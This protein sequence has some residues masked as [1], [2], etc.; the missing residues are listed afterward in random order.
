MPNIEIYIK[1]WDRAAI[2]YN[3]CPLQTIEEIIGSLAY[4]IINV[5]NR[6]TLGSDTNSELGHNLQ[7]LY[8]CL[9]T[10]EVRYELFISPEGIWQIY[11]ELMPQQIKYRKQALFAAQQLGTIDDGTFNRINEI[12]KRQLTTCKNLIEQIAF[13][14]NSLLKIL[15]PDNIAL[16]VATT[17]L[18]LEN[19]PCFADDLP[20]PT[21]E[22]FQLLS[23]NPDLTKAATPFLENI[24]DLYD[25]IKLLYSFLLLQ[26]LLV[27][28]YHLHIQEILGKQA[29]H[30]K[31]DIKE[32]TSISHRLLV[33]L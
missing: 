14:R 16:H 18:T 23:D 29:A 12:N 32:I 20:D 3:D 2:A 22:V 11:F 1:P 21:A 17:K 9:A 6:Q 28:Q 8:Q 25:T 5:G 30:E 19:S 7:F 26:K 31:R 33:T 10:G 24:R 4:E 27:V 13:S 15:P